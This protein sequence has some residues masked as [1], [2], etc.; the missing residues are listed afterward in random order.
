MARIAANVTELIGGTPLVKLNR[1]ADGLPA[2]VV[3]K[4]V[5]AVNCTQVQ[6]LIHQRI[7]LAG[8]CK[9]ALQ[10][11]AKLAQP[12]GLRPFL[13]P[14]KRNIRKQSTPSVRALLKASRQ[15]LM[16]RSHQRR[17]FGGI[18]LMRLH[19]AHCGLTS[20]S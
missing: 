18:D 1:L 16:K 12:R 5:L 8:L 9:N 17:K 4:L 11:A 7:P 14:G 15:L 19:I 3:V 20:P 13:A 6:K 10:R 2:T